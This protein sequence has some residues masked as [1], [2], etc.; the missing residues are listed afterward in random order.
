MQRI[1]KGHPHS[2]TITKTLTAILRYIDK[3]R[4]S[5]ACHASSAVVF[6]LLREQGVGVS[7]CLG[8]AQLGNVVFNHSWTEL[9]GEVFDVSIVQ[10]LEDEYLSAPVV[11]G[12]NVETGRQTEV[13]YGVH[14]GQPDD[15]PT[16]MLRKTSF[17]DF[18]DGFPGHPFG[19]WGL[20]V[21]LSAPIGLQL[22]VAELRE[23]YAD[24]RWLSR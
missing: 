5:G 20:A 11:M 19:L 14:S 8:E 4:W 12:R 2:L 23:K 1:L 17:V 6:I 18:L 9:D 16:A 13:Q 22:D 10:T 7:L 21:D 3:A 15:P 24:S